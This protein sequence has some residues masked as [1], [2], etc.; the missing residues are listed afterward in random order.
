[1]APSPFELGDAL[2]AQGRYDEAFE[3]YEIGNR[4]RRATMDPKA[5]VRAQE[6]RLALARSLYTPDWLAFHEGPGNRS[7][8]PIFVLGM[9][10]SGSTLVE[11][12]LIAHR[13]V[14]GL[15]ECN[16]VRT[17][18]TGRFPYPVNGQ[19][20]ERHFTRMGDLYLEELRRLG[21]RGSKRVVDKTLTNYQAL[22]L[23]HLM[24]PRATIIHTV[25][26]PV[27]TCLSIWRRSFAGEFEWAY[28]L[29]S[30]A[31]VYR[32]YRA[33]MGHWSEVLPGR[34]ETFDHAALVADPE[35]QMRRLLKVCGGL[36]WSDALLR[37]HTAT[38]R[39]RSGSV[40]QVRE[41]LNDRGVGH[42][43]NYAG[44]LGPLLEALGPYARPG[45]DA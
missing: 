16:A 19:Y 34:I 26:D 17:I 8:A 38:E 32:L 33:F 35:G 21:W 23:I 37:F 40:D 5:A 14:S 29:V 45:R 7:V 20:F 3:Q 13:D 18:M 22:G 42:W 6:E 43:R 36:A 27:D 28:D 44:Q 25:R 24:F 10:R 11:Q 2:D 15:G 12:I 31:R 41:P 1:M 39:A 4:L 9:P 30:I